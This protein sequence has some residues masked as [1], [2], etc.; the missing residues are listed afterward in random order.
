MQQRH[1]P[2]GISDFKKIIDENR[3]Y[4]DKSLLIEEIVTT[5]IQVALIP[6]PR[7]FGKTLNLSMLRYFF[8]KSEE[9]TSYLFKH[10]KVWHH[11]QCRSLQGQFPVI[12]LTF[13]D[14]KHSSWESTFEHLSMLLSEEFQRHRY[15]LESDLFGPEE[16]E[17]FQAILKTQA[18]PTLCAA[19]L[20][21]LSH[22]LSLYHKQPVVL[23]IDEYDTPVH[24][25]YIH[26]Y[27]DPTI[28]FLRNLLS[29]CLKDNPHLQLG[30][31]TGILRIAKES[32]FSGLNNVS[33]FTLLNETFRDKFGLLEVEVSGLLQ[34][35]GL[36]EKLPEFKRWYNG[37]RVGSCASIY[38]PWSV[39]SCIAQQGNLAP[40]WVNTSDN[41]LVK[42][43]I[44]QGTEELKADL[45]ELLREGIL[46][47]NIEDGLVFPQLDQNPNAVWSLLLFTGYLTLDAIPPYGSP[48][49]LKIPN[50]EVGEL[51]RTMI[52][53]WFTKTLYERR[54]HLLL[55]SLT[56]GDVDTFSQ[57]F[58]EFMFSSVSVF[59]VPAE[60]SEKIYHAFVLGMLVGLKD[61]YEVKSNR[62]SGLGRYDVMLFPK[63]PQDLGIIMEFK[64]VG[65]FE[66]IDVETALHSAMQQIKDKH[67]ALELK[68]RGVQRILYLA[69]AF[70]G[71][72]V[73]IQHEFIPKP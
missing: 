49:P 27:Y 40:Y 65:R 41:A 8:E 19:S 13:K 33:T 26:N 66:N 17:N 44:A 14:V 20:R 25:A 48:I 45:E 2:L 11:A 70:E 62:E 36:L 58:K 7:R 38:N 15:L 12:F 31:L 4:V 3:A 18:N 39:L 50:I 21:L 24:S 37:Y 59:D 54:Y 16:Q 55:K 63:N 5:G 67:Y 64:K 73:L 56:Q 57:L 42:R 71:K 61:S 32:I 43:L 34:E 47:K 29:S 51:Y 30:V 28:E 22:W 10:L 23:L 68:E 72:Q 60:A 35:Y 1:L 6:R 52:V 53:E 69:F 46:K 9:N